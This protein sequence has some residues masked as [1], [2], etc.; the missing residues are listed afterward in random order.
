VPAHDQRDWEF[1]R[2]YGLRIH[3]VIEPT[4]GRNVDLDSGAFVEHGRLI[5]SGP[6]DGLEFE[7]AFDAIS[8][9]FEENGQGHRRVNWRLRD[10]G[11]SRQR[12]WGCPIPMIHCEACG[13][14]PVPD[15]DLPVVLTQ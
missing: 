5:N 2:R 3:Q 7:K 15:D 1:A 9:H 4:D 14:V 13:E 12:Y 8:K 6:F 10:W 11:I